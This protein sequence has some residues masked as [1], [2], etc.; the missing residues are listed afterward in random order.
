MLCLAGTGHLLSSVCIIV[1][2][3][4]ARFVPGL[5]LYLE[6]DFDVNQQAT[7][8]EVINSAR[9]PVKDVM[10]YEIDSPLAGVVIWSATFVYV[11]SRC[12]SADTSV[13]CISRELKT[14][15]CCMCYVER[16]E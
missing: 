10:E 16:Q 11:V 9:G 13:R 14:D 6:A 8:I 3:L 5:H 15:V 4:T 1:I 2:I 7:L 12:I